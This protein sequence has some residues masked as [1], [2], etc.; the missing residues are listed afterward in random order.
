MYYSKK[1]KFKKVFI[2]ATTFAAV[3]FFSFNLLIKKNS[4]GEVIAKI[5]GEEIYK[6]EVERKLVDIFNSNNQNI[7]T[8]EVK[9][10]PK[11]VLEIL[12]K[13]IYLEKELTKKAEKSE[14]AKDQKVI[15]NIAYAKDKILRQSYIENL[16]KTSVTD[17]KINE[18]YLEISNNLEGK[19][20]YALS[21]IVVKTKEEAEK[22]LS[23]IKSAKLATN[24]FNE[25]AKKYSIDKNTAE[26]GGNLDYILEDD[27][28]K[29]ISDSVD[30]LKNDEIS[31]PIQTKFGWHLIKINDVR[32]AKAPVFESVKENIRNQLTQEVVNDINSKITNDA[33]IEILIA[34]EQPKEEEK[35][36]EVNNSESLQ[37]EVVSENL[38]AAKVDEKSDAELSE[39]ES[40]TKDSEVKKEEKSEKESNKKEE[41]KSESKKSDNKKGNSDSKDN[42]KN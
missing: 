16:I 8:P 15:D 19:K 40:K 25:L 31:N 41:K 11:E 23:E 28:I 29:E 2:L 37:N 38:D 26:K 35:P 22:I 1:K 33:K 3:A 34:L 39:E 7:K 30:Q 17:E 5:N 14:I 10:L 24:K 6:S 42:K 36:A 32:E 20:E 13:D 9:N 21:H 12:I 18:K 4:E 27:M